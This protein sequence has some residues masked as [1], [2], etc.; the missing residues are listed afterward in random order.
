MTARTDKCVRFWLYG[1][2]EPVVEIFGS[3]FFVVPTL[4]ALKQ[5]VE[6]SSFVDLVKKATRA[7]VTIN[8]HLASLSYAI[9][10]ESPMTWNAL[11]HNFR[12]SAV[13]ADQGALPECSALKRL[14]AVDSLSDAQLADALPLLNSGQH[15]R[16]N[17][18]RL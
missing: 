5:Q 2:E 10:G 16:R 6:A 14:P 15:D 8:S 3:G 7:T 4:G 13:M 11:V 12:H 1:G 17:E 18:L 9:T